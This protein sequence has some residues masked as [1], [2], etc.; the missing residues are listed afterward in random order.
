MPTNRN[1]LIR[2]KTIDNCLQNRY[3]QWTLEDLIDACSDALYEY[4]GIDKGVSRRTVQGD[5]Q[6]MRSDKL[7]YNAPIVVI[8]KKFYSYADPDY[9]ITNIPLTDQDLGK[10]E[11]AVEFMKQFQ[12]FSHFREL[13][14][15]VQK[16]E[17]HI[18]SQKNQRQPVI[19]F[20]K[21]ENLKGLQFLDPLYKAIIN[22]QTL[23]ITYQSFRA[24]KPG[25]FLF[26]PYLLKEFRNRWFLI[27][28]RRQ[29]VHI[30]TLALDRIVEVKVSE[31]PFLKRIDFNAE[32]YFRDAIGVTVSPNLQVEEVRL[33]VYKAFAPYVRTKPVHHS[34]EVVSEKYY[35]MEISLKVQHN[36]ELEKDILAFGEG[37]RVIAP[38]KLKRRIKERLTTGIDQYETELPARGLISAKRKLEHRGYGILSYVYTGRE[39]NRLRRAF[40]RIFRDELGSIVGIRKLFE[41]AP[42]LR[43]MIL[44]HNLKRI[45]EAIDPKARL[46]K[47]IFFDKTPEANWYVNWHQDLPINVKEK[48]ETE[49]FTKWTS[50]DGVI[51]VSP[52]QAI[53]ES[54]FTIRIHL[55]DTNKSNGALK[56]IP[57]TH[58]KIFA[59]DEIAT[60]TENT[61]PKTCEVPSGGILLMK[62]LLLHA[63]FRS[64]SQRQRRVVHL[65]F[66]SENLPEGLDWA[67]E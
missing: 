42:Q 51:S 29:E 39:I 16:L 40:D 15:M 54:I 52:P 10:L 22:E 31:K 33:F 53:S 67:E 50:R 60:I 24:R 64:K 20:E 5:I 32:N 59:D 27:G 38:A 11:E 34:Q 48:V 3:R 58:R 55:D 37:V 14:V 8:D 35:G 12:G 6:I 26:H 62:P 61:I 66:C 28:A 57:G 36:F 4:E 21:N 45:L 44:N 23:E 18:Y 46:I 9:S 49:G 47:G 43:E 13:D 56:I 63:S 2:Y 25:D 7:G 65:E 1:A 17:A 30:L 41:R 19:D